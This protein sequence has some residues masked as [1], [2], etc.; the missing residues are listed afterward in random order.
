MRRRAS[1]SALAA[2]LAEGM[3]SLAPGTADGIRQTSENPAPR[4]DPPAIGQMGETPPDAGKLGQI[5]R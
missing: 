2:R 1:F 3:S 5:A 4:G